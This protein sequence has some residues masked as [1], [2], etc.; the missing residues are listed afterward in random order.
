[1]KV[2]DLIKDFPVESRDV[3]T[4]APYPDNAKI[5]SDSQVEDIATSIQTFG[6][7]QPIVVDKDGIVI[8]GH[9]RRLAALRLGLKKVPVVVRDDLTPDQVKAARLADNR[10]AEG[11]VDTV[12]LQKE[13]QALAEADFDLSTM[14]FDERELD[15]LVEDV[16][17]LDDDAFVP[18]LEAAVAEVESQTSERIEKLKQEEVPIGKALGIKSVPRA[19]ERAINAFML[20]LRADYALPPEQAFV[21][22]VE[23]L[24][25]Q[26]N[27]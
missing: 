6:F 8:K 22:F 10:V 18:D 5:H 14:G 16:T 26:V 4:I 7:D 20:K 25:S 13:L 24:I 23:D 17:E 27:E 1:M 19:S 9:G 3:T 12:L 21:R 15:F 11:E 2:V